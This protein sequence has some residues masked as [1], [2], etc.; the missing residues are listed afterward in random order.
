MEGLDDVQE[1]IP[2]DLGTKHGRNWLVNRCVLAR[3]F[4]PNHPS[5]HGPIHHAGR[6]DPQSSCANAQFAG[7]KTLIVTP[8]VARFIAIAQGRHGLKDSAIDGR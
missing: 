4:P 5:P 2:A 7:H 6:I 3:P 8:P 1:A